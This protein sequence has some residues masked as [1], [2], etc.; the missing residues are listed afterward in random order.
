MQ[1]KR[2]NNFTADTQKFIAIVVSGAEGMEE[3]RN[4]RWMMVEG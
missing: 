3:R 4:Q 1:N 2:A